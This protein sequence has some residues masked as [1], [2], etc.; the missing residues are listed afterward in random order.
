MLIFYSIFRQIFCEKCESSPASLV[1][2]AK[3][4]VCMG[5]GRP[6]NGGFL[7]EN[8]FCILCLGKDAKRR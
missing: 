2:N 8:G 5:D 3:P 7:G 4:P 6:E 1:Q